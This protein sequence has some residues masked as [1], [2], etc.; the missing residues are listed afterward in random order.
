MSTSSLLTRP[1]QIPLDEE[2]QK[3]TGITPEDIAQLRA[4]LDTQ[5]HLPAG[6]ITDLDL[7]L[8]YHCCNKSFAVA[9]EV[10]DLNLTLRTLFTNY[11][12]NRTIEKPFPGFD[13]CLFTPLDIRTKSGQA[14]F[15]A[16]L[17]DYDPKN[18]NFCSAVK[19]YLMVT[20]IW[21]YK[22]GTWPGF[23]FMIDL[24][25]IVLSHLTKLDIQTMQQFLYFLQE[26]M[27]VKLQ[28]LHFLNAPSFMD[29]LM[30]IIK[31]FLKKE[32]MEVLH[33]H[34][35]GSRSLEE[36]VPMA[37]LPKD[38]GGEFKT[39]EQCSK[40][41]IAVVNA[42]ADYFIAESNKRVVEA[43][44]PGKPKTISDI[45]GGVEGSFKKLDID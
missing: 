33:I 43:K 40:D 3:N 15:Y 13:S 11:F 28:G 20:D 44:R 12:K 8:A 41:I 30:M 45:F 34:Q 39:I 37:G 24:D 25:R 29:K 27:L 38:A 1:G 14:V 17:I 16:R 2:Y 5:P 26:G 31:P 36:F 10:L 32:L 35:I 4:W 18:F 19:A 23:V 6:H 22:E 21:Q 42:N 9:K 7:I